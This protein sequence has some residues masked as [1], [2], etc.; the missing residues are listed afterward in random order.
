M[1][2]STAS[3]LSAVTCVGV[4]SVLAFAFG[5]TGT[6]EFRNSGSSE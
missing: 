6:A 4:K 3:S 1:G 2:R 5:F